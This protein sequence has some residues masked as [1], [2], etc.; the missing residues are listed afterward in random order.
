MNRRAPAPVAAVGADDRVVRAETLP[1]YATLWLTGV[2][3]RITILAVPPVIPLIHQDLRLNETAVGLLTSLPILLLAFAAVPGSMLVA[4]AGL[5]RTLLLGLVIVAVFGAARGMATSAPAL[6]GSTLLM[7]VGIA[8]L[9]PAVPALVKAW[10]PVRVGI[11]TAIFTNGLLI[12]EIV[13]ASLTLPLVGRSWGG[14]LAVWS[15]VVAGTAAAV[16]ALVTPPANGARLPGK[17]WPSWGDKRTWQIGVILGVSSGLYFAANAF[18][19]DFLHAAGADAQIGRCLAVLNGSQLFAL[20]PVLLAPDKVVGRRLPIVL[21]G[22][23]AFLAVAAVIARPATF[24]LASAAAIGVTSA[25]VL[26]LS[27]ALPPLLAEPADVPRLAAGIF[28]V[29]YLCAVAIPI[30]G[31]AIWDRTGIRETAFAPCA[32]GSLLGIV[33][34]SLAEFE[35]RP[36]PHP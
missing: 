31:G 14:G 3:L 15:L 10:F 30:M 11:A 27:L 9:Q 16:Y 2:S 5:R 13:G 25:F 36:P 18:V 26:T 20:L 28:T 32:L 17:W 6:F 4:R 23:V 24:M 22:I 21:T 33:L 19:P 7:G 34:A 35:R 8:V 12:G 29:A 1:R